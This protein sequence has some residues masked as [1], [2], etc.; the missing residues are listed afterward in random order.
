[1]GSG[2]STNK[3]G[4]YTLSKERK[5]ENEADRL[6]DEIDKGIDGGKGDGRLS[7]IELYNAVSAKHIDWD[8]AQI[9][10]AIALFD[11]DKD[12]HLDRDEFRVT[13]EALALPGTPSE[14]D[15]VFTEWDQDESG[16]LDLKEVREALAS[17]QSRWAPSAQQ[18]A[19]RRRRVLVTPSLTHSMPIRPQAVSRQRLGPLSNWVWLQRQRALVSPRRCPG[20]RGVKRRC[21]RL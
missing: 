5:D 16:T 19:L 14:W 13:M 2:V 3:S 20:H 12:G 18:A 10:E 1:M 4:R 15:A 21:S 7:L 6:F 11:K 9:K 8:I 17:R